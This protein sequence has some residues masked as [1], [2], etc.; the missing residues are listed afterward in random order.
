MKHQK[1]TEW[2]RLENASKIFPAIWNEKDPKVFRIA[3]ELFESVDPEALQSALNKTI[4]DF[5]IYKSVLKRGLFWYYFELSDIQPI[6]QI[7]SNTI[8][9]PI[10]I[11]FRN[12]LLFRV[13]YYNNRINL[14]VFHALSDGAGALRFLQALVSH[15]LLLVHKEA[16]HNIVFKKDQSSISEQM[17]DS[18]GKHFIGSKKKDEVKKNQGDKRAYQIRGTGF[19]DK[20]IN[21]IEGSMSTS[22]VLNEAHKQQTTLTVFI[23]ALYSYAIYKDMSARKRRWPIVLTV[24]VNLRSYFESVT[25]RNFFS[26]INVGHDYSKG[27]ADLDAI[28]QSLGESFRN[29]LTLEQL[30]KLTSKHMAMEQNIISRVVPLPMKN[31]VIRRVVNYVDKQTTTNVSNI[32]KISVQSELMPYIRQFSVC[33]SARR[34][35]MTLCSY[36][37]KLVVSITSPYRETDIQRTFFQLLSKRGIEI[38]ISSN[39]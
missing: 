7:E 26:Y 21:V 25:A 31:F 24:P 12:N 8:C 37:D 5:P 36:Q 17:D 3:C 32:G 6:V 16:F 14:E 39:I 38:E 20:R 13:F 1:D 4:D 27:V 2:K 28:I 10:Y 30:T 29:H 23:A 19:A 11:G 22:A 9:A 33:T 18:F 15:Y 35:Q 34:P